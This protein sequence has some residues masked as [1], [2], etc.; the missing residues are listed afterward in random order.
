[1]LGHF[2]FQRRAVPRWRRW[3]QQMQRVTR[4]RGRLASVS[5]RSCRR[6][7][8]VGG[9][10]RDRRCKRS[11]ESWRRSSQR[12]ATAASGMDDGRTRSG[13]VKTQSTRNGVRGERRSFGTH[14]ST[15]RSRLSRT[16]RTRSGSFF[17]RCAL[18]VVDT[19]AQA[20]GVGVSAEPQA[21]SRAAVGSPSYL[22]AGVRATH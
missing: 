9:R 3:R 5:G 7:R 22:L 21:L 13:I 10:C 14:C 11:R 1:M 17:E 20:N 19:V 4:S 16:I 2:E 15:T 8:G 6:E 12:C 18:C